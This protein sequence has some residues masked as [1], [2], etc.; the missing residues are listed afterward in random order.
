MILW[1]TIIAI[2]SLLL[3]IGILSG[4]V[5][6]AGFSALLS[7]AVL[8][9]GLSISELQSKSYACAPTEQ[10]TPAVSCTAPQREAPKHW[11]IPASGHTS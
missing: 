7:S 9:L 10:K 1:L 6:A 8:L 2:I 3:V 11:D 4:S 5:V